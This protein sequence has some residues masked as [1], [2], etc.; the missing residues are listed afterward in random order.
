MLT[1]TQVTEWLEQSKTPTKKTKA[2]RKFEHHLAREAVPALCQEVLIQS[3]VQNE[4]ENFEEKY[5]ATLAE[6]GRFRLHMVKYNTEFEPAE[7]TKF[8]R[9]IDKLIDR[10]P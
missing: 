3:S 7:C 8:V 9:M 10:L 6:I 1:T 4:G 2:G 5:R